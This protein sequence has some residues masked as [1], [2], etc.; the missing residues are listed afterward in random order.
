MHAPA[1]SVPPRSALLVAVVA[2]GLLCARP[3]SAGVAGAMPKPP[4][5]IGQ[6]EIAM[7]SPVQAPPADGV[8]PV[9]Y[10]FVEHGGVDVT[11]NDWLVT[12]FICVTERCFLPDLLLLR[13]DPGNPDALPLTVPAQSSATWQDTVL[14]PLAVSEHCHLV[15]FMADWT[16]TDADGNL[17]TAFGVLDVPCRQ[18]DEGA[19]HQDRAAARGAG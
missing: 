12:T 11:F 1:R 10:A 9:T 18:P 2:A 5:Q 3:T 4:G 14:F 15:R 6:V 19:F 17:V 7:D 13:T 8:L 16:G